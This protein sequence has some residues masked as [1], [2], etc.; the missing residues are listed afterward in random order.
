MAATSW[1]G[2][3]Y[4]LTDAANGAWAAG[5]LPHKTKETYMNYNA[6]PTSA[7][8][9]I[10]STIAFGTPIEEADGSE[11]REIAKFLWGLL[12]DI[13]TASDVF[14][15]SCLKSYKAFYEYAMKRAEKRSVC[16]ESDGFSLYITPASST[17]QH[18]QAS[19]PASHQQQPTLL[20]GSCIC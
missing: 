8:Q 20:S 5:L 4:T 15:P 10:G 18:T 16:L 13:D 11:C 17:A 14:K 12:D 7:R 9:A 6:T 2:Y 3:Y 19:A 1:A